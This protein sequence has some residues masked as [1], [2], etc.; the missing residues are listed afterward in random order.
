[1]KR[2]SFYITVLMLGIALI[3]PG[4][5]G[6]FANILKNIAV[7]RDGDSIVVTIATASACEYN[8]F[9]TESK[10]ERIVIDLMG[11]INNLDEKQ[12]LSLPLESIR[13]IRT[14]Q[15]KT[16]PEPQARLVLD[17]ERPTFFRSYSSG[18]YILVILP[19]IEDEVNFAKWEFPGSGEI[20]Q[21]AIQPEE[22]E[23][24]QPADE[25]SSQVTEVAAESEADDSA[26]TVDLTEANDSAETVDL[27]EANDSAET[28]EVIE[29][30]DS[31]ETV[32]VVGANDSAETVELAEANDSVEAEALKDVVEAYDSI[33]IE[34]DK[35][36]DNAQANDS[37]ESEES[38]QTVETTEIDDTSDYDEYSEAYEQ[39]DEE[40]DSQVMVPP[41]L[42]VSGAPLGGVQVDTTPKRK[43][44]E[45][46]SR[47]IKDPF[48][49]LV[50]VGSGK[51]S[52]GLPSLENLKLVGILEDEELHRALL[53]DSEGNGYMLKPNDKIHSGY[54]V[55][56]TDSKAIFQ[57]TEY[58]WTRTVAL[59]LSIPEFK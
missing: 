52:K 22:A 14:S 5:E 42:S 45:Y 15:F 36:D 25:E 19:A 3:G 49:P 59:E 18:E 41:Q 37:V 6:A 53:E 56:V 46:A 27:A 40:A 10:P 54:L 51:I 26:E 30:N 8:I 43:L 23:I 38:S 29:A 21:P 55:A 7:A 2:A 35:L 11:V 17:I 34:D 33:K 39:E 24:V 44:V 32:E 31:A 16:D 57:I 58:G 20:F 50:G 28:V 13:S 12:F 1:M 9:L 47:G 48:A 4:V